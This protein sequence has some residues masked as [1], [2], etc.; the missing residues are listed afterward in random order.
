MGAELR[1]DLPSSHN[2]ITFGPHDPHKE[3]RGIAHLS[4]PAARSI[5]SIDVEF[6]CVEE[7]HLSSGKEKHELLSERFNL[8]GQKVLEKG[9]H[10]F[11][12]FFNVPNCFVY[13]RHSRGTCHQFLYATVQFDEWIAFPLTHKLD[14]LFAA[15]PHGWGYIPF[16]ESVQNHIDGLGPIEVAFNTRH[17][18]VSCVIETTLH[19]P[20]AEKDLQIHGLRLSV[21]QNTILCSRSNPNTVEKLP[22]LTL[23]MLNIGSNK[24]T[25][26]IL[27][28]RL[29]TAYPIKGRYLARFPDD[30]LLRGS[31]FEFVDSAIKHQHKLLLEIWHSTYAKKQVFK[32]R[33]AMPIRIPHCLLSFD[34]VLLPKYEDHVKTKQLCQNDKR[35]Y[36]GIGKEKQESCN[37]TKSYEEA[38]AVAMSM[39]DIVSPIDRNT[40][41]SNKEGFWISPEDKELN[42][43]GDPP[44]Y[45]YVPEEEHES[46]Y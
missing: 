21:E 45:L 20:N 7:V 36:A 16:G 12:F 34:S 18:T 38:K 2:V 46:M 1:I 3:L 40:G 11:D 22:P 32:A 10:E 29:S 41:V 17:L 33:I 30:Q 23:Q 39:Y 4:L 42:K 15:H 43:K 19:L 28:E 24:L 6:K 9:T 31:S 37:C 14:L 5:K 35:D 27:P 8:Y 25:T 44:K 13:E 26:N